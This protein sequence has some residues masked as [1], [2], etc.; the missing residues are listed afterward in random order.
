VMAERR[1][2]T[3]TIFSIDETALHDGPGVR[4]T[5]Y[6]KGCP[7][8]CRWCHSPESQA[9]EPEIVW[10]ETRCVHCGAC[11][12]ICP[13]RVRRL[14]LIDPEDRARCEM[15]GAC[16]EVCPV[17]ALEVCGQRVTAGEVADRAQR[18]MPFFRR[19][20][21]GVTLTGGEPTAQPDFAH[22]IASL[23]RDAGIH[24]AVETCGLTPWETLAHLAE[25][26]ELWLYD[27]KHPDAAAHREYT[28]ASNEP[29]LANLRRLLEAGA[30][31][32][33]RVPLIPGVNDDEATIGDLARLIAG[34]GADRIDL[35]PFNPATGGKYSWVGRP[36]PMP[37]AQRQSPEKIARLAAIC[38]DCGLTVQ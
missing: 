13:Q 10:F 15:C 38:R 9:R 37:G 12:N 31:V 8:T 17:G 14:G 35:L 16:V 30:E 7:L 2:V 28:G 26:V 6:L 34:L 25:V 32:V 36:N 29:I 5:V 18:L 3:G 20:G 23:C 19:T 22:A 11:V 33:V 21:G 24:V 1:D 4:M 27:V